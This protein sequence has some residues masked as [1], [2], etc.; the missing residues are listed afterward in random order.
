MKVYIDGENF[1]HGLSSILK[2]AGA[3]GDTNEMV[4]FPV[5]ALLEDLTES[6]DLDIVYFASNIKLPS[7][8][9]P[10]EETMARIEE[11][12]KQ[13]RTWAADLVNQGIKYVKAGYLKIKSGKACLNCKLMTE[14]L[15]E[16]GVDVRIAVEIISQAYDN[17][18]S[19]LALVS[20][21][22][23]LIPAMIRA[24]ERGMKIIY[25]C[26][27]NRVNKAMSS[28]ASETITI[29]R[30]KVARYYE[31]RSEDGK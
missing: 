13:T 26:F 10:S 31:D 8:Y 25:I 5:K 27:A 17:S 2:D 1:R 3:V 16:K 18:D 14:V 22:S 15:Q 29:S 19:T 24:K 23:D 11:I 12:K 28:V 30:K 7:G 9:S 4:S 21:D 20:S 6:K